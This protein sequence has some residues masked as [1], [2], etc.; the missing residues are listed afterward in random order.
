MASYDDR[1]GRRYD[2]PREARYVETRETYRAPVPGQE[3][4]PRTRNDSEFSVDPYEQ[5]DRDI[6]HARSAEPY[7]DYYHRYDNRAVERHRSRRGPEYGYEYSSH[8]RTRRRVM[9]K[10]QKIMAALAGAALFAGGKE[11]YDRYEAKEDGK[12]V[13]RNPLASAALGA[14]GAL[15]GYQGAEIYEKHGSKTSSKSKQLVRARDER[16][17]D[18]DDSDS[19]H[20]HEKGNKNFIEKAIA[21]AG[22]GSALKA[23]NHH[24]NRSER[25]ERDSRSERSYRTR[26]RRGSRSSSRSSRRSESGPQKIQQAAMAS[27]LA[28]ASEAF[29]VSKQPGSWKGEKTKRVL[30]AAISAGGI[31]AAHDSTKHEKVSLMESVLGGLLANR[32]IRGSKKDIEEDAR[33]GRSRSRSRPRSRSAHGGGGSAI[34]GPLAAIAG[35]IAAKKAVGRSRSRSRGGRRDDSADSRRSFRDRSRSAV[36]KGLAKMGIGGESD[37]YDDEYHEEDRHHRRHRDHHD[38]D[39]RSR[40]R[41]TSRRDK[42]YESDSDSG[43][44]DDDEKEYR[45]K[46]ERRRH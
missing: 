32:A 8:E 17:W 36:R 28:G 1:A 15:A 42:R 4:V 2:G 31:N 41:S 6:R 29:R 23:M 22:L 30:T 34:A 19:E 20:Y 14:A 40:S 21:A 37:R 12:D 9:S 27:L 7:D 43:N 11:L 38:D 5:H 3:L 13:H 25:S 33:T 39:D 35:A 10:E 46:R 18:S 44:T 26:S 45:K 24:D 16:G